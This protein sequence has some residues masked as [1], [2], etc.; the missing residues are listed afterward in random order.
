MA[1]IIPSTPVLSTLPEHV[2]GF[3]EAE[4]SSNFP[5]PLLTLYSPAAGL[6]SFED[7]LT[8]ASQI[9]VTVTQDMA[10]NV[11]ENTRGHVN[12]ENWHKYRAGRITASN[13]RAACHTDIARPSLVLIKKICYPSKVSV[14]SHAM[15]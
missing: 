7:L 1:Q 12:T 10:V 11:E 3:V 4:G 2:R 5:E 13:M 14:K 9:Q 6:L 15:Q 8:M